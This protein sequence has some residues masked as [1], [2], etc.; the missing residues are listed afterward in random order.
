MIEI[1]RG[2][3]SIIP[4]MELTFLS[5]H[6]YL[7]S[8]IMWYVFYEAKSMSTA[9]S[10]P[11]NFEVRSVIRFLKYREVSGAKIYCRMCAALSYAVHN[12]R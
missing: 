6:M 2:M 9:T 5:L 10:P 3:H 12:R 8:K 7:Y 1:I 11:P 4:A